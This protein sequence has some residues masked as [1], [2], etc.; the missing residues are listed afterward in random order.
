MVL[1]QG[2]IIKNFTDVDY[3]NAASAASLKV[4]TGYQ[5]HELNAFEVLRKRSEGRSNPLE[6]LIQIGRRVAA[7]FLRPKSIEERDWDDFN[8]Y[9]KFYLKGLD[10]ECQGDNRIGTYQDLAKGL[11]V[12]NYSKMFA[13]IKANNVRMKTPE[14]FGSENLNDGELGATLVRKILF[15]IYKSNEK[16]NVQEGQR[17]F[18]SEFGFE[19]QVNSALREKIIHLLQYFSSL[20]YQLLHW[21]QFSETSTLLIAAMKNESLR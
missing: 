5:I 15:T 10:I 20:Q 3:F 19:Y 14:D 6:S 2:S 11:G 7:N 8:E 1:I 18:Q 13:I 21:K 9:E 16:Q 12:A 4:I 17:Y